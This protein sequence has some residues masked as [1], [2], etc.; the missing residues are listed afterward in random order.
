MACFLKTRHVLIFEHVVS[1]CTKLAS[2][3]LIGL[4]NKCVIF[5]SQPPAVPAP[6]DLVIE[7][8][9]QPAFA[10][11]QSQPSFIKWRTHHCQSCKTMQACFNHLHG[12]TGHLMC[13]ICRKLFDEVDRH[14]KVCQRSAEDMCGM[15]FCREF[16]EATT[17]GMFCI[18]NRTL[19]CFALFLE[20]IRLSES[21]L[22]DPG[23]SI[24][25]TRL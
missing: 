15:D 24:Y 5:I 10:H 19:F 6:G 4:H 23:L 21:P 2:F 9:V 8:F 25:S 22:L 12:C 13:D 7:N 20:K 14:V 17:Q 18:N 3:E 16:Y 1:S 11:I